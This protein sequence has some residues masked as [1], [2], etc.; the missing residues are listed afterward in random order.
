MTQEELK[1]QIKNLQK[2]IKTLPELRVEFETGFV[3]LRR[4]TDGPSINLPQE[5]LRWLYDNA[6]LVLDFLKTNQ[7]LLAAKGDTEEQLNN[8]QTLR[9]A[10]LST[11]NPVVRKPRAKSEPAI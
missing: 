4:L 3:Q 5:S 8:K 2:Q 1:Q 9:A 7:N 6:G 11:E 10:N